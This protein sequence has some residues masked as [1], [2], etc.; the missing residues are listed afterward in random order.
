MTYTDTYADT[1]KNRI[2][3]IIHNQLKLFRDENHYYKKNI[4]FQI[5]FPMVSYLIS[6]KQRISL[7]HVII[8]KNHLQDFFFQNNILVIL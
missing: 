5:V 8:V 4:T 3:V 1:F 7:L 2:R 6:Q